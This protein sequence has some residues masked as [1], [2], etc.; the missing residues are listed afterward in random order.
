MMR[1]DHLGNIIADL[2]RS[3]EDK[4]GRKQPIA[5]QK[6]HKHA[7]YISYGLKTA[8]FYTL[9]DSFSSRFL[10]LSL[11]ESLQLSQALLSTHVGELG[12]S[13]IRVISL[14]IGELTPGHFPVLDRLMDDF[15][16][17]SHV[18]HFCGSV[19]QPLLLKYREE[20]LAQLDVWN[21]SAQRFKRRAS[22]IVF[23]RKIGESGDFVE[24]ALNLCKNL[25][26]EKDPIVQKGVGWA[27]KDNLRSAPELVVPFIKN[28][29]RLGVSST[30]TLYAIRDLK[31]RLRQEV[32]AVKKEPEQAKQRCCDQRSF[33]RK[34]PLC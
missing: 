19:L 5:E 26:W 24:E 16:S 25:I 9:M 21:G 3:I 12:H 10:E 33:K 8:D 4:T 22:V 30:I 23:V 15:R 11:E 2:R 28:L 1:R 27:L 7:E 6:F 13:G 29:R 31:G 14:S 17:W 20:T 34:I 18:D 32:L